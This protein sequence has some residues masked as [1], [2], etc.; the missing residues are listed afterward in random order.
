[1]TALEDSTL[2]F[3]AL[4]PYVRQLQITHKLQSEAYESEKRSHMFDNILH[5]SKVSECQTALDSEKEAGRRKG[6]KGAII[7]AAAITLIRVIAKV[8]SQ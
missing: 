6:I 5:E 2:K 4:K 1:M 3:E 8:A 7:G